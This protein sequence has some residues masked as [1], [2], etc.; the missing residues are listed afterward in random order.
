LAPTL[1]TSFRPSKIIWD[2]IKIDIKKKTFTFTTEF[3]HIITCKLKNGVS[4]NQSIEYPE[5]PE[6]VINWGFKPIKVDN[7]KK[8]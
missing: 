1:N 6:Y 5:H 4:V 7:G 8:C 2:S 3:G